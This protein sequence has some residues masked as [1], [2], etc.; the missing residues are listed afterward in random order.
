MITSSRRIP[1]MI[2]EVLAHRKAPVPAA[3]RVKSPAESCMATRN[4]GGAFTRRIT[5]RNG[6]RNRDRDR[7]RR[8]GSP[9]TRRDSCV[10]LVGWHVAAPP[11][12]KARDR[13]G[14]CVSRP[15]IRHRPEHE[16]RR[17]LPKAAVT[18]RWRERDTEGRRCLT[19]L[20]AARERTAR[21]RWSTPASGER[22]R[23]GAVGSVLV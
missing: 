14:I 1:R 2:S 3:V 23:D 10:I 5:R 4:M 12:G 21:W 9:T 15:A 16:S 6:S 18:D 20:T 7:S 11:R 17:G 22:G 19:A 13:S 8:H